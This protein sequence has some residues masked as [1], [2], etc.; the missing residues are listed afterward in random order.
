MKQSFILAIVVVVGCILLGISPTADRTTWFL[1]NLPVFIIL[2]LVVFLQ[3]RLKLS[4]FAL[5]VMALHAFVLMYG[6]HYSYAETPLGFWARD[7]FGF[8]RNH[9]DRVGHLFQ[10]FAPG[11]VLWEILLRTSAIRSRAF[12][13]LVVVSFAL[14]FSA[15]YELIEWAAALS[16]GQEADAFLGTQGDVWDTQWDMFMALVGAILAVGIQFLRYPVNVSKR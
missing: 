2:P 7:I 3:P 5:Y 16:L 15:V 4:T 9:Y 14:A 1:E 10:G 12:R 6:G 13:G 8:S 11:V